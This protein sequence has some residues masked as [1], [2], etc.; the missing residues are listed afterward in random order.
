MPIDKEQLQPLET[1]D[2]ADIRSPHRERA[3]ILALLTSACA[4]FS[5]STKSQTD[6]API[7]TPAR[8]TEPIHCS[9]TLASLHDSTDMPSD[10][11]ACDHSVPD[12][13][14]QTLEF[15]EIIRT[16]LNRGRAT[17]SLDTTIAPA[18]E[19]K[20]TCK[21]L[22]ID[23]RITPFQGQSPNGWSNE[24]L[25]GLS[26]NT[27]DGTTQVSSDVAT[28]LVNRE[29]TYLAENKSVVHSILKGYRIQRTPKGVRFQATLMKCGQ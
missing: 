29:V 11:P 18:K 15:T 21:V 14:D 17:Y 20:D 1:S 27:L 7:E 25:I 10:S 3:L 23:Q 16:R 13:L 28:L 26:L 4:T 19:P 6:P 8:I 2:P 24:N 22:E 9:R 5:D 12:F